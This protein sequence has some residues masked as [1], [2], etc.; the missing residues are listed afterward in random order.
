V[1]LG[2]RILAHKEKSGYP[3]A[4]QAKLAIEQWL[5][6]EEKRFTMDYK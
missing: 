2:K 3:V 5:A 1:E 6:T 4:V